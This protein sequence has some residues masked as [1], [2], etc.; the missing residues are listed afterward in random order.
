[1]EESRDMDLS[2]CWTRVYS[3]WHNFYTSTL[4]IPTIIEDTTYTEGHLEESNA[5]WSVLLMTEV[6][7]LS[8]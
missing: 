3:R 6:I 1:M 8:Q 5:G 7:M 2:L 4:I